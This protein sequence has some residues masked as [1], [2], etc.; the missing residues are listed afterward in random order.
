MA[1][2]ENFAFCPFCI[3]HGKQSI[4]CEGMMTNPKMVQRF[5]STREKNHWFLRVC[6]DPRCVKLCAAAAALNAL[7]DEQGGD[8]DKAVR[9][10]KPPRRPMSDAAKRRKATLRKRVRNRRRECR[11]P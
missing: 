1:A 2:Q 7:L 9:N 3:D 5:A 4:V 10:V 8:P 6:C 11:K